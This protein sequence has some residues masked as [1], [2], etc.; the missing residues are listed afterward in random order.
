MA[1]LP[2][3]YS[4]RPAT[5]ADLPA[6]GALARAADIVDWG[7]PNTSDEEIADH[8]SLPGL[9]LATDTWVICRGTRCAPTPG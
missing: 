4:V 6:L 8:W 5:R 2:T 1:P 9:E 3:G 7:R